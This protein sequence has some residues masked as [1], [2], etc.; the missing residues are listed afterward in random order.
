MTP[1]TVAVVVLS[2]LLLLD[3]ESAHAHGDHH[4][5]GLQDFVNNEGDH[6]ED[7]DHVFHEDF[8]EHLNIDDYE[9]MAAM[10]DNMDEVPGLGRAGGPG[11]GGDTSR[12]ETGR[13]GWTRQSTQT[14]GQTRAERRARQESGFDVDGYRFSSQQ[15]F[16]KQGGRC[17]TKTPGERAWKANLAKLKKMQERLDLDENSHARRQL[18]SVPIVIAVNYVLISNSTGGGYI[19]DQELQ[20][21]TDVLNSAFA[22]QF[23]F[24]PYNVLRVLNDQFFSNCRTYGSQFKPLYRQGGPETLN[25]YTC[26]GAGILGFANLPGGGGAT[27]INDGVVVSH[28]TLPGRS[29][30]AYGLGDVSVPWCGR[31]KSILHSQLLLSTFLYPW[32][33]HRLGFMRLAIG[34]VCGIPLTADVP[35][36]MGFQIQRQRRPQHMAAISFVMY[37]RLNPFCCYSDTVAHRTLSLTIAALLTTLL[38]R[39]DL[40]RRWTV[41][42]SNELH[43]TVPFK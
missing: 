9:F 37:V 3:H 27:A 26:N 24:A 42:S 38:S 28:H 8:D 1:Y 2:V 40:P 17:G 41:R 31:L 35:A 13:T 12:I 18:Q 11:G 30:G 20:A 34:L 14:R 36:A 23:A 32:M 7:S 6:Y 16:I 21:Q 33:Q 4:H 15:D 22:P 25:F 39:E 10:L 43:G 29:K 19:T 5:D